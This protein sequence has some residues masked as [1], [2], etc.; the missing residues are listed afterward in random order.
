M[1]IHLHSPYV[2]EV[3]Y[4]R[5]VVSEAIVAVIVAEVVQGIYLSV[6]TRVV[7]VDDL[8]DHLALLGVLADDV[9]VGCACRIA[10]HQ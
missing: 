9:C 4:D 2:L 1:L 10:Y 3:H 7:D 8:V 5:H 6:R